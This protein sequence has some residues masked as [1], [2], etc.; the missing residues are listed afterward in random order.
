MRL[1]RRGID[2]LLVCDG[3]MIGL[4]SPSNAFGGGSLFAIL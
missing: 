3:V 2:R 1:G 4:G